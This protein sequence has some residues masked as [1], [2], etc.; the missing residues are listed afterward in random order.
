[1]SLHGA[2]IGAIAFTGL[3]VLVC[4]F[5]MVSIYQDVQSIWAELDTE[6]DQFKVKA[7][8]LWGDMIKMG[9]GSASN[10]QRRQA[11][12]GYGASGQQPQH[13]AGPGGPS[14]PS[15]PSALTPCPSTPS[16][17][18]GPT[19]P[20]GSCSP[21]GNG[22]CLCSTENKCP[23]GPAGAHRNPGLDGL[24]GIPGLDGIPGEQADDIP[25]RTSQRMLQLSPGLPPDSRSLMLSAAIQLLIHYSVGHVSVVIS[26]N[27][28]FGP[29]PAGR[30][31][32]RGMRGP[33]GS[34]GFPG[35]DGNP[36]IPGEQGPSG[37]NGD[38]GKP[39]KY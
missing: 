30:P 12:G 14:S 5:S 35:R 1:M 28:G 21:N 19:T 6:M 4:L 18:G 16:T 3:T 8:D 24:P 26:L 7:D 13:P 9:A 34:P 38:D 29:G 25:Q 2:T 31:G 23:A 27:S 32:I 11:Y 20:G 33:K 39:G 37:P 22:N 15:G 10:R 36:G 17:P